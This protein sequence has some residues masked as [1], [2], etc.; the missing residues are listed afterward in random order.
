MC[1]LFAA[2][3]ACASFTLTDLSG[4]PAAGSIDTLAQDITGD[5]G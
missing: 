1:S 4:A 5:C 2:L 3:L